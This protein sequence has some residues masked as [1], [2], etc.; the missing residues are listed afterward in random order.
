MTDFEQAK[1]IIK[2]TVSS[3]DVADAIGFTHN[4]HGRSVCPFHQGADNPTSFI[5]Y[6]INDRH[7]GGYYC[8]SCHES[9]DVINF[10]QKM[11][12]LSYSDSIRWFKDQFKMNLPELKEM[13]KEYQTK[14]THEQQLRKDPYMCAD[15]ATRLYCKVMETGKTELLAESENLYSRLEK[16]LQSFKRL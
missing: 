9:G 11:K 1:R 6:P 15:L 5:L 4:K 16:M 8:G 14:L 10:V 7:D 3:L 13:P 2:G 12:G